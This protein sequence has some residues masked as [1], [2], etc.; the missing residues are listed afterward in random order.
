[1]LPGLIGLIVSFFFKTAGR[2]TSY[3]AEHTW[4]LILAAVLFLFEN[5]IN[6][7]R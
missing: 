6:K 2:V 5:Y 1:M 7:R 3:L 4:L